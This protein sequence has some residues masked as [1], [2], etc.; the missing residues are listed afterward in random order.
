MEGQIRLLV[1]VNINSIEMGFNEQFRQRVREALL[2]AR[3]KYSGTDAAFARSKGI[4]VS[5]FSR[6]KGGET[7]KLIG[8]SDWVRLARE[9]GV[10]N[11]ADSWKIART[12]VYKEIE[13]NLK[14]CKEFSRAMVL[15]D[16]PGIGKSECSRHL[17]RNMRDAFYIDCSQCKTKIAF[18]RALARAIGLDNKGRYLDVKADVKTCLADVLER[19]LVVL[20]DA[21]LLAKEAFLDVHELWNATEGR[22]GWYMIGDDSLSRKISRGIASGQMGYKAIFSRFNDEFVPCLPESPEQRREALRGLLSAV[23]ELNLKDSK[24][25]GQAVAACLKKG[26]TLRRLRTMIEVH[27]IEVK[28]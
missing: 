11:R 9:L 6:L 26:A 20:D 27:G 16:E 7:E 17:V 2:E 13:G 15:V 1:F 3:G 5:V 4:G 14:F 10:G 12:S 21:G 25:V 22:C 28:E 8:L 23:A 19:P 24:K 18:T